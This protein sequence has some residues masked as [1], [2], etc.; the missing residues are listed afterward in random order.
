MKASQIIQSEYKKLGKDPIKYLQ[1]LDKLAQMKDAQI[2]QDGNTVLVLIR[3][4]NNKVQA[5]LFTQDNPLEIT[6]AINEFIKKLKESGVT[7][8]YGLEQSQL[9]QMLQYL[10]INVEPSNNSKYQWMAQL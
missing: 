10:N 9:T 6:K 4:G 7:T 2:L 5:D 1:G 8:M 3:L